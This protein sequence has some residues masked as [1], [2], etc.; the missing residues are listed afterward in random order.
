[1]ETEKIGN[2]NGHSVGNWVEI[3]PGC[4]WWY[5]A[6][7]GQIIAK[8]YQDLYAAATAYTLEIVLGARGV[9]ADGSDLTNR[10]FIRSA[11]A[12]AFLSALVDE[13]D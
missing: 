5:I 8:I 1:M 4:L 12:M 9:F 3:K 2:P 6:A 13:K 11:D 10:A 7:N